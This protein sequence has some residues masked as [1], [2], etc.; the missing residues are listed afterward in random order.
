MEVAGESSDRN[1]AANSSSIVIR[2]KDFPCKPL[3]CFFLINR[4]ILSNTSTVFSKTFWPFW[5][6]FLWL[7]VCHDYQCS[8]YVVESVTA[9]N[10]FSRGR[11]MWTVCNLTCLK[12]LWSPRHSGQELGL[13][14]QTAWF[15]AGHGMYWLHDLEQIT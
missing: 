14:G 2:G 3:T 8:I 1:F 13:W 4:Q 9:F 5:F 15:P 7:L 10:P 6:H 12:R 11:S